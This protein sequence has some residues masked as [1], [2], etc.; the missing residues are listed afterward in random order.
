MGLVICKQD[1]KQR[2]LRNWSVYVKAVL[3]IAEKSRKKSISSKLLELEEDGTF[4]TS[5]LVYIFVD[6][7]SCGVIA[8]NSLRA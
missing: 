7:I 5:I 2:F 1:V 3:Q 6:E 8:L 4:F